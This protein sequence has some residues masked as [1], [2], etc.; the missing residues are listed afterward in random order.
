MKLLFV[1]LQRIISLDFYNRPCAF[2]FILKDS[3]LFH[4]PSTQSESLL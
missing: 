3:Y 4:S 2:Y 1:A